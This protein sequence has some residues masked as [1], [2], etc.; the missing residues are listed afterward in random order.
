MVVALKRGRKGT[1]KQKK[2]EQLTK[3]LYSQAALEEWRR[4]VQDPF[5]RLEF[6]TTLHFLKMYLPK[7]G[8]ILDAGGGPGRYSIELGRLGYNVILLDLASENLEFARRQIEKAKI[9]DRIKDVVQGS[10]TDLSKFSDETFD[11]VISLGGPLSNVSEEEYRIEATSELVRVAKRNAPIFVSVMGK[12]GTLSTLLSQG[13]TKEIRRTRDFEIFLLK[14]DDYH[15]RGKYYIHF[16]TLTELEE[17]FARNRDIKILKKV[18]LEGLGSSSPK[19]IN[20]LHK[21][22]VAWKNWMKSHYDLCTHPSVVDTSL[23]ILIVCRKLNGVQQ[24]S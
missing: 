4:L 20:E 22:P 21:D 9:Q 10:I 13:L 19:E 15:Y 23:H 24:T 12:L 17:L 6:D 1:M 7:K 5:H 3:E 8:L 16:F 18:G 14:G 11:A 2:A